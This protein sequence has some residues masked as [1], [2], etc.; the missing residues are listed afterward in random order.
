MATYGYSP[1]SAGGNSSAWPSATCTHTEDFIIL[2]S[3][4][5]AQAVGSLVSELCFTARHK[6]QHQQTWKHSLNREKTFQARLW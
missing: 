1:P 4:A 2:N 6:Q 5:R 3:G